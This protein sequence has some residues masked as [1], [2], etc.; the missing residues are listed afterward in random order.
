MKTLVGKKGINYNDEK[1]TI[2]DQATFS[3]WRSITQHD[4]SGWLYVGVHEEFGLEPNDIIVAFEDEEGCVEVY[5]YGHGGVDLDPPL[6]ITNKITDSVVEWD[7][8]D[9]VDWSRI[10]QAISK[11]GQGATIYPIDTGTSNEGVLI[12]DQQLTNNQA[13]QVYDLIVQEELA[14]SE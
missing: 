2:I 3:T 11:C 10:N 1:G 4:N 9:D 6:K 8:K 5:T 7:Y 12:T 13:Q 14:L